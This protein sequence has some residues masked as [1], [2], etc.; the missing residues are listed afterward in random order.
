MIRVMSYPASTMMLGLGL[1][2]G[3]SAYA[4]PATQPAGTPAS[5]GWR[6]DL[7]RYDRPAKLIVEESTPTFAQSDWHTRPP[8]M[9]ALIIDAGFTNPTWTSYTFGTAGLY[10]ATKP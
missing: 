9:K 1:L 6:A 3:S 8:Q 2:L 7:F 10:R 4:G 5:N